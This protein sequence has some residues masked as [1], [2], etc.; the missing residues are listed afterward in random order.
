[1]LQS[2]YYPRHLDPPMLSGLAMEL[3]LG[4]SSPLRA[5]VPYKGN[6]VLILG[7]LL[8]TTE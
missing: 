2:P 5:S 8:F 4:G 7:Y 1:M 6:L 3:F